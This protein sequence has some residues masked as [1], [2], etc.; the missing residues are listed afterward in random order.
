MLSREIYWRD[1]SIAASHLW[2]IIPLFYLFPSWS[3]SNYILVCTTKIEE[4]G[5]ELYIEQSWSDSNQLM[6]SPV[7]TT[8]K[9][10][11]L[12][13]NFDSKAF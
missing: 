10:L 7:S 3:G 1:S 5:E 12:L 6:F 9:N 4:L 8:Y 13:I 11:Y 2:N